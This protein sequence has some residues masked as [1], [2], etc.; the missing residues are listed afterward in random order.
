MFPG[1]PSVNDMLLLLLQKPTF[2]C[3][4]K[5]CFLWFMSPLDDSRNFLYARSK[6]WPIVN[7]ISSAWE[8]EKKNLS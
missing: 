5:S 1:R 6:A 2:F 4:S 3:N 8:I 7:V